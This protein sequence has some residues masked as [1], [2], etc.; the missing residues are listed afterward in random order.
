MKLPEWLTHREVIDELSAEITSQAA[1]I[2]ALEDALSVS[3]RVEQS[4]RDKL[5]LLLEPGYFGKCSK[6]RF[7]DKPEAESFARTLEKDLGTT[8]G[9]LMAYRCPLCPR[10]R[11]SMA[12]FFHVMH[13]DP[14]ERGKF[15]AQY[16]KR[17]RGPGRISPAD[18]AKLR[19]RVGISDE[20]K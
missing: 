3:R 12:H 13:V 6:I 10:Q 15:G 1:Q 9:T 19:E 2:L 16:R 4:V 17:P 5:M 8:A 18:I 20:E 11:V 14:K 7:R